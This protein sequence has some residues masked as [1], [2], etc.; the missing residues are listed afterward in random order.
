MQVPMFEAP[1]HRWECH[2]CS[3]RDTTRGAGPHTRMHP[4]SGLGGL[5]T[6]MVPEGSGARVVANE[7]EDYVGREDVQRSADGRVLS[8]ISTEYPDGR[9][10]LVVFAPTASTRA[11]A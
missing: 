8:S 5:T 10:D 7:R 2:H 1:V 9:N 6:P 11:N 3:F 4:C